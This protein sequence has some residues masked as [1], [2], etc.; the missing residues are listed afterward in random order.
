MSCDSYQHRGY[1]CSQGLDIIGTQ[2]EELEVPAY[3]TY[4]NSFWIT[5][6]QTEQDSMYVCMSMNYTP[7]FPSQLSLTSECIPPL[8]CSLECLLQRGKMSSSILVFCPHSG[9]PAIVL[10][11]PCAA[12]MKNKRGRTAAGRKSNGICMS[13]TT[14]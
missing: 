12:K 4:V 1:C 11:D 14:P 5:G 3:F 8:A 13:V 2:T 7:F 6:L 10:L 9:V